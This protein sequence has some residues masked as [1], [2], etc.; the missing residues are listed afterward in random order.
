M[1]S[2]VV[3]PAPLGPR[4]PVTRPVWTVN[5]R[6]STALTLRY[7]FVSPDTSIRPPSDMRHPL[8]LPYVRHDNSQSLPQRHYPF[9]VED[10]NLYIVDAFTDQP[11]RGNPAGVLV[12]RTGFPDDAWMQAFA[13]E[14][15]H[16]E[17]AFVSPSK[18]WVEPA[19][20]HPHGRGRPVRARHPCHRARAR[21]RQRLPH[22]KRRAA[23]LRDRRRLDP[24]GLPG[25]PTLSP[26]TFKTSCTARRLRRRRGA[27]RTSWCR[28]APPTTCGRSRPTWRRWRNSRP[29][30]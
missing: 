4:K 7:C 6:S 10:S 3:L 29:A 12:L 25:R 11:F 21:R 22:P 20:V 14:L 30:G 2:V 18:G 1:R 24:D 13:A 16:S 27:S 17:T 5:E 26:S 19:M 23:H 9:P 15:N 8:S 28:W